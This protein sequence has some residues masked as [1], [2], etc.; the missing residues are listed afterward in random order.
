MTSY[1]FN[2]I[3][4]EY[5]VCKNQSVI[6]FVIL[7]LCVDDILLAKNSLTFIKAKKSWLSLNFEM[8]DTREAKFILRVKIHRD[9]YKN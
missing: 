1:D 5:C 7:S 6:D 9:R 4:E 8:K 3:V 2:M